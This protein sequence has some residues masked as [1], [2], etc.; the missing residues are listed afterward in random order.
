MGEAVVDVCLDLERERL[1]AIRA[2]ALELRTS[3]TPRRSTCG[4]ETCLMEVESSD[5]IDF[6]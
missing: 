3:G 4:E 2:P 5:A 6:F 1:K